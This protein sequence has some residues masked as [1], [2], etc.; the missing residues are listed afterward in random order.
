MDE[1]EKDPF[2]G[3][4]MIDIASMIP[5][6]LFTDYRKLMDSRVPHVGFF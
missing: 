3:F 5:P 6:G 1:N 2:D 4:K